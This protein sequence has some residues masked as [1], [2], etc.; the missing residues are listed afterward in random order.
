MRD[1]TM[2][3]EARQRH[4]LHKVEAVKNIKVGKVDGEDNI[5]PKMIKYLGEKEKR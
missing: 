4:L 3:E 2:K 1:K 5:D